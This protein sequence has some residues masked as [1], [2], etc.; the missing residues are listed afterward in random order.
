[1]SNKI[2]GITIQI[3]ADTLGLDKALKDVEQKSKS[4]AAEIKEVEKAVRIT[5]DSTELWTQKQALLKTALEESEKKLKLL[6]DAQEQVS[7]QAER[8][9]ITAEQYRAFQR[10]IEYARS[11]VNHYSDELENTNEK[12]K[13]LNQTSQN[14]VSILK[15]LDSEIKTV[16]KAIRDT[17]DSTVLW[18]QKQK[19]LENALEESA[20]DLQKLE[21]K[22]EEVNKQFM[23]GEI[24][25]EQYRAFQ[26]EIEYAK[27]A[28]VNYSEELRDTNQRLEELS[29]TTEE[30]AE[31]SEELSED[32]EDVGK[33]SENSKDGVSKF[34]DN[35]VNLAKEGFGL[36]VDGAKKAAGEIIKFAEDSVK[37]GA[38]F[39]AAMSSVSAISGATAEE[40]ELLTAKAEEMGATTKF[41]AKES[42]EAFQYMAMAGWEAQDMLDGIGGVLDLA[43]ASGTELSTT[44]DIVTDAL[45][46]MKLSAED[47]AHFVDVMAAA[48]SNSNTNV[49]MLGESFRY[50]APIVGTMGGNIEDLSLALGIM[51]NSG[52]KGSMAGNSLK[53][54]LVNLVKPTKQQTAAMAELGL[55]TSE[56]QTVFDEEK[57]SKAQTKV[58]NKLLDLEKAQN[59][60]NAAVEKYGED[61]ANAENALINLQKAENNL[62]QAQEELSAAQQ[63]TEKTIITGQSAFTDA[64]GNMKPLKEILDTLRSSL[65]AINVDLVDSEGNA[66]EYEDIIADLEQSE[67]GLTQ[68]E[69]LKNAAIIFG[70]QNLAGMLSIIN[71]SEEDYNKLADSIANCDGAA[72]NMSS[73]MID[74]LQGDMTLLNSAVDGMKISLS[75]ELTPVIR[76]VVQ[77]ITSKIPD[78][79]RMLKPVF[80]KSADFIK[81]A[82]EKLPA[83][84]KTI[85]ESDAVGYLQEV[86]LK[87]VEVGGELLDV[88]ENVP[89]IG[90]QISNFRISL[91]VNEATQKARDLADNIQADV[92]KMDELQKSADEQIKT[93]FA[94]I[95]VTERLYDNLKDL[96]DENGKVKAGYEDRVSFITHELS[97][98]TGIEI[99]LVDGQ[100]AKYQE[101]QEQIEETVR[102]QKAQVFQG[103]YSEMYSEALL[104][105]EKAIEEYGEL[106]DIIDESAAN[107]ER[108]ESRFE[109]RAKNGLSG[110]MFYVYD[111]LVQKIGKLNSQNAEEWYKKGFFQN[112]EE[113]KQYLAE[114]EKLYTSRNSQRQL[115]AQ[116]DENNWVIQQYEKAEEEFYAGRY[117]LA[118][119]YYASI[120]E[121]DRSR[122]DNSEKNTEEIIEDTKKQLDKA[123]KDYKSAT[124]LHLKDAESTAHD[125]VHRAVEDMK[126]QGLTGAEM[127][128]TG[129]INKLSEIDGFDASKLVQYCDELGVTLGE[130]L[131]SMTAENFSYY[132]NDID[133]TINSFID[134]IPDK[135]VFS[136]LKS[137]MEQMRDIYYER[138]GYYA[139]GGFLRNGQG[140][141]AEAGPELI[142]IVSGGAK[143]TPLTKN[144]ENIPL[145]AKGGFL[146]RNSAF[147]NEVSPELIQIMNGN[148]R[149]NSVSRVSAN[150]ENS[151]K[152]V[153]NNYYEYT[154][155][156]E[157]ASTY[158]VYRL[159]EDL[160]TAR[161]RIDG[162][163]GI[164][165]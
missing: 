101:L 135:P 62:T 80:E 100:I 102:K 73:T 104:Q 129:I 31:N 42:A 150:A 21:E 130:A 13:E 76:N 162:G 57:I 36:V 30:T 64:Y 74:N 23:N 7:K 161:R 59:S 41:T 82:L 116:V 14:D 121:F 48:T 143:I 2:K 24:S 123:L 27:S 124:A 63:G 152:T 5:G 51:A 112:E 88:L 35:L 16:E 165:T 159:N 34:K 78:V 17:G 55:I 18:T 46:A 163:R 164:V 45:T 69:Q 132:M 160:D 8:G 128:K 136:T 111:E 19:L 99:E 70:K 75:K 138:I 87:T 110:N 155:N 53:N 67:E 94:D 22:Q 158:D 137:S 15:S 125:S 79:E 43:A 71:A 114:T 9:D 141:V 106:Q 50:A 84:W 39:E 95:Y 145:F 54:A 144:S 91:N 156:A 81:N 151:G 29:G 96:V 107:V 58:E 68:A 126:K 83:L 40:T 119:S 26:R 148:L 140:I 47:T 122:V 149:T 153:I 37:T 4:A 6:E 120:D 25:A 90:D 154:T 38:E 44:S 65:G 77:F 139:D 98:A 10:E 12:I 105:N 108:L 52:I 109:R 3:G 134:R 142:E 60:Y 85:R 86:I 147:V 146:G 28:V 32:I 1:M 157:I 117:S 49:E 118:Q 66:R 113:Y 92:D 11:A 93:D 133:N 56:T 89:I 61:S 131:G 103:A 33:K 97:E 20:K 127:L 115:K 72:Q